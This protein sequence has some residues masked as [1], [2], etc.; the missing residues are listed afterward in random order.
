MYSKGT[1]NSYLDTKWAQAPPYKLT[2]YTRTHTHTDS[3]S[4]ILLIC[5]WL[6]I[7]RPNW[8]RRSKNKHLD[9]ISHMRRLCTWNINM[10]C[11]VSTE[12]LSVILFRVV[13]L[14]VFYMSDFMCFFF[15][16]LIFFIGVVVNVPSYSWICRSYWTQLHVA[17]S[18][19][20]LIYPT[21]F[22]WCYCCCWYYTRSY[23]WCY[24][25]FSSLFTLI[26]CRE[27]SVFWTNIW[28]AFFNHMGYTHILDSPPTSQV[29]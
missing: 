22:Y 23:C 15:F 10:F 26:L 8:N 3:Y 16:S 4:H 1:S 14:Y 27:C 29:S 25:M 13:Y 19:T 17:V 9:S 20:Y 12:L 18:L 28:H 2:E 21:R 7:I 5:I 24:S 11:G 6:K